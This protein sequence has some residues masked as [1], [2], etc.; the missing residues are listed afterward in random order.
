MG[1]LVARLIP[2]DVD[3]TF[4]PA[5]DPVL[6]TFDLAGIVHFIQHK[7][8]QN[9]IVLSGAGISVAAGL[10]DFRSP[11]SGIYDSLHEKFDDLPA[12][13]ALF[14]IAYFREH[15]DAFYRLAQELWPAAE[16][17]EPT[18]THHFIALLHA[19]GL[20]RR[21]YT[22]NVDSLERAAGLPAEA[23]VQAHGSFDRATCIETGASVPISELRA[24]VQCGK[25]GPD[26]WEA[27]ARRHGGLVKP[28]IL[29]F[30]EAL[31]PRLFE[32]A[33]A[34]LAA[35]DLL[36]ILGSSLTVEPVASLVT[37]LGLDVP[38]LVI[39]RTRVEVK[40]SGAGAGDALLMG[41]GGSGL[42]DDRSLHF[43]EGNHRNVEWLGDCDDGVRALARLLGWEDDLE[44]R[45]V[46]AGGA[47][48]GRRSADEV[49]VEM[50]R[51]CKVGCRDEEV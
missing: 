16:A 33:M 35:C 47:A 43:G 20:L 41:A 17:L 27:L 18:A 37:S 44:A 23:L 30:G 19:K 26:G 45:R 14:D 3:F 1:A 25:H 29:F 40:A 6:K 11:G 21:A 13:E 46:R 7:P 31:P 10:P 28:D 15:P 4:D 51:G 36:L 39:S 12:P 8:A 9:V 5:R 2:L 50:S 48:A 42:A 34:D 32:Q 49:E 22:Q 38:R 24:A